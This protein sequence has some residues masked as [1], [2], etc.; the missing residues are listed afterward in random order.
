MFFVILAV[1]F[2]LFPTL[3]YA[4]IQWTGAGK[5]PEYDGDEKEKAHLLESADVCEELLI[6]AELKEEDLAQNMKD[7]GIPINHINETANGISGEE[8]NDEYYNNMLFYLMLTVSWLDFNNWGLIQV[9]SK[10][11]SFSIMSLLNTN[12]Q[13]KEQRGNAAFIRFELQGTG[14]LA[15]R[16]QFECQAH[17][18]QEPKTA[19]QNFRFWLGGRPLGFWLGGQSPPRV[20]QMPPPS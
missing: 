4:Y 3:A 19:N 1:Y 11:F 7:G 17:K 9:R 2:F 15:V 6:G 5:K 8:K 20:A 14:S 10:N 16:T 12:V 13:T 18:F